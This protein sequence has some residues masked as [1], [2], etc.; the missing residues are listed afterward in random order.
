MCAR[1]A[2]VLIHTL[3]ALVPGTSAFGPKDLEEVL[4]SVRR[5][6]RKLNKLSIMFNGTGGQGIGNFIA[7]DTTVREVSTETREVY[8]CTYRDCELTAIVH[9]Q[10]RQ[11][12]RCEATLPT[13][14]HPTFC[15]QLRKYCVGRRRF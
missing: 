2:P 6:K 7:K 13:F 5:T 3:S 9:N 1:P 4:A 8:R 12:G 14:H 10:K 15:H 11:S